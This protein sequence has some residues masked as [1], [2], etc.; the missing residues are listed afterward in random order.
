[1]AFFAYHARFFA[2]V[3]ENNEKLGTEDTYIRKSID[4]RLR[5]IRKIS[6]GL[7]KTKY[8]SLA[9]PL[10][11]WQFTP[12]WYRDGKEWKVYPDKN[13]REEKNYGYL[14][15]TFVEYYAPFFGW[16]REEANRIFFSLNSSLAAAGIYQLYCYGKGDISVAFVSSATLE[17]ALFQGLRRCHSLNEI[18]FVDQSGRRTTDWMTLFGSFPDDEDGIDLNEHGSDFVIGELHMV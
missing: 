15:Y 3:K 6:P 18:F 2:L 1:M 16:S 12:V 8:V 5:V 11:P 4:E 10:N 14:N 9:K 17:D 7:L 13:K